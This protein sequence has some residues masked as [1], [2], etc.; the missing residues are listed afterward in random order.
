MKTTAKQ[1]SDTK[2][3]IKVVLDKNDLEKAKT[4]AVS[5]LAKETKVPGFRKGK[6]PAK[7]AEK[8]LDPN[9]IAS[10]TI[11]VAVRMTVPLA[12][13]EQKK[14]AIVVPNIEV[15]KYVPGE[16]AE[17][18]A[19][20]DILPDVKLG[21]YK[22]LKVKREELKVT[23]KD[24]KEV[25][26]KIADSYAEKKA[27]KRKTK[28][29]DEV[30]IDFTGKVDGKEFPGGAAKDYALILGSNTFI[31]GFED[32]IIGHEPGDKFDIDVT[33][34]KDY[35]VKDLAGKPAVFSILIKQVNE[36]EKPKFDDEFAKKCG[37]FKTFDDLKADIKKNLQ[38]QNDHKTGEKYK[39]DLVQAL[40]KGSKVSAP[41]VMI[42]DQIRFIKD[43]ISRN[44]AAQG[45][46]FEDY[47]KQTGQTEEEWKKEAE[48]IAEARV[49]AS[50]VLQVLARDKKIEADDKEVDAKLAELRDVYGKAPEALESLK[51]PQVRQDIKNRMTI[52]KTLE[53]LVKENS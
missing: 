33:F 34:P 27:V 46:K 45:L 44:A 39:D 43:D 18:T 48:K 15:T 13:N 32:G 2:V 8:H 42:N 1:L 23:E 37:P 50:L 26:D 19:T 7:V 14:V 20:A 36:L 47:L 12:F 22:G 40:V 29:G 10:Q 30:I 25:L 6:A 9:A 16:S 28:K 38:T 11:D 52:E 41:E 5:R 53:F 31:P 3:E 4:E 51:N 35:Q 49:K 24:I 17:Y 21:K